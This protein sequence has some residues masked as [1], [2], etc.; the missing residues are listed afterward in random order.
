[1]IKLSYAGCPDPPPAISVQ[2]TLK[3]CDAAKNRKTITKNLS[4]GGSRSF[5]V[6]EVDTSK[7]FVTIACYDK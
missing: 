5:K 2:F 7:K 1:M 4:F 3:M 6:I